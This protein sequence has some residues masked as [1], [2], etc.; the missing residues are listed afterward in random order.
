MTHRVLAAMIKHETNGFNRT[1]TTLRDFRDQNF[2]LGEAIPRVY[3]G[4]NLEMGGFL[5]AAER[6][7]WELIPAVAASATSSGPST[8]EAFEAL[9]MPLTNTIRAAGRLDGVL[10]GLHGSM[11][12]ASHD[13]AEG[14]ILRRVRELVGSDIPV[15]VTLD[16]HSNVTPEMAARATAIVAFR[17]SPHT[18]QAE[19]AERAA[20]I[21]ARTLRGE[22]RPR[23]VLARRPMLTGFDG[24][25]THHAHGPMPD[26]LRRA[27]ALEA[28]DPG[29]LC[30]SI[31][32]G[33]SRSD[34][35]AVGPSVAVTGDGED[36]RF[37]SIAESFMD[38][39]WARRGETTERVLSV[40][41]GIAAAREWRP[42]EKPVVL[43][44]YGD[45][46]GG[47]AYGDGTAILSALIE[48]GIPGAVVANIWDPAVA[49]QAVAAGAG[50]TIRVSLGGKH[51]PEHGG[52][53]VEG[54]ARVVAVSEGSFVFKG[55]YGTGTRG[56]YGPSAAL[57][58]GGVTA[59][60][61]TKNKGIYDLEQ[62]RIFG[63]EPTA[64]S[65]LAVKCMHGHRAEYEP[66]SSR[67]LDVDSGGITSGDPLLFPW[68]RVVRPIWPL[69][70]VEG[71]TP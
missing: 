15:V 21:L 66:I 29:V 52:G 60:V 30:V 9:C 19:T 49:A 38:E 47:G 26:A 55:R 11:V 48:A 56:H 22:V 25:R 37:R 28:E 27:R 50:A 68:Q 6:E 46:P 2:H 20:A 16:P 44:D 8:D 39:C 67:C 34:C 63:I 35:R 36:P 17:T 53:P 5:A 3:R 13:D 70:P 58:I 4:T 7:G 45:A 59:I 42:G 64:Q 71:G 32:S 12:T 40:A 43:G 1:P 69:D 10:L 51:D 54:T 57:E 62:L 31:H 18:D 41:E 61:T 24:A 33:F 23:V 14:E 65:V